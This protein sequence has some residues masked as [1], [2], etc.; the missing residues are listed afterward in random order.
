[1]VG[2]VGC[3]VCML[4]ILVGYLGGPVLK[5]NIAG[6]VRGKKW[7]TSGFGLKLIITG[8]FCV[9]VTCEL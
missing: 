6:A 8:Y 2:K 3:L 4:E 5:V 7:V 1:M 9:L